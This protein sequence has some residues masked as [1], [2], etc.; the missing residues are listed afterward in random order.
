M[1]LIK[2]AFGLVF[3]VLGVMDREIYISVLGAV[4]LMTTLAN[5]GT[6]P[7]NSCSP[8]LHHHKNDN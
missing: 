4:L 2:L 6:C 5:K 8:H 7:G 1:G 3:I